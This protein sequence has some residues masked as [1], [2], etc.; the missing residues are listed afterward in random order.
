MRRNRRGG[1]AGL[2]FGGSGEDSFVAVV[3][4]KLT[5]AL[6]FILLLT[7]V[8]MALLPKAVDMSTR[9]Q[10]DRTAE[11]KRRPLKIVTP[12]S[13]PEAIAGRPYTVALAADGGQGQL[14]W[15][16]D[17]ALPDGLSFDAASGV[18]TG[19]PSKGTPRPMDLAVRVS[20]GDKIDSGSL[21]LVVFQS[22]TPLATPSWWKPGIPPIPWRSWLDQ[23][24]GFL[25]L[26]LVHLVGMST[27]ANFERQAESG[28]VAIEG[29]EASLAL[30]SRRFAIY[31]L[32]VRLST[33]SATIALAVWLWTSRPH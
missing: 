20:D 25:I 23:G 33:A 28:G 14:H 31:R 8:I 3:V 21:K 13:L 18:L 16:L 10:D 2:E 29:A 24:V 30:P 17:G 5:G 32:L 4:T 27:L 12:E 19:T 7:M 9:P 1:G 26:W 11:T 15:S 22:D 6:L